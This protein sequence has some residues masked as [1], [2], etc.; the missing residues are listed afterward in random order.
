MT[1]T[2]ETEQQK[3]GWPDTAESLAHTADWYGAPDTRLQW[4]SDTADACEAG[5]GITLVVP[6]GVLS[7]TVVS[8]PEFFK[9]TAEKFRSG[10]GAEKQ[11]IGNQLAE[12]F[13]DAAAEMAEK[14]IEE[15]NE[16]F[17][18]GERSEPR[19]PMVRYIHLKDARMS[20]PGQNNIKL[21][22]TRVLLSQVAAWSMGQRWWGDS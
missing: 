6:G 3:S 18:K 19:W 4:M 15:T 10:I 9:Q 5:I 16:A 1:V 8:A 22:Y 11:R 7:G 2:P 21:D 14:E 13:F 17:R 12:S 20:A